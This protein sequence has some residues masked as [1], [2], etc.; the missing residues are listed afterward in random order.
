MMTLI[1][2]SVLLAAIL[3]LSTVCHAHPIRVA[4]GDDHPA[5][6]R[7]CPCV[8]QNGHCRCAKWGAEVWW[9]GSIKPSLYVHATEEDAQTWISEAQIRWPTTFESG[10]VYC[11]SCPCLNRPRFQRNPVAQSYAASPEFEQWRSRLQ[12]EILP[13][14]ERSGGQAE[15]LMAQLMKEAGTGGD[16]GFLRGLATALFDSYQSLN[17]LK[18]TLDLYSVLPSFD[19]PQAV[20]TAQLP[21]SYDI[22][23]GEYRTWPGGPGRTGWG[24]ELGA[25]KDPRTIV[26]PN[27]FKRV[28]DNT[29]V[30]NFNAVSL[31]QGALANL[32]FAHSQTL[33][34]SA[35]ADFESENG[36]YLQAQAEYES[37]AAEYERKAAAYEGKTGKRLPRSEPAAAPE[38]RRP[39]PLAL[40]PSYRP[41]EASYRDD[42]IDSPDYYEYTPPGW[43]FPIYLTNWGTSHYPGD[44]GWREGDKTFVWYP[45][46]SSEVFDKIWGKSRQSDGTIRDLEGFLTGSIAQTR[47]EEGCISCARLDDVVI[48]GRHWYVLL[49][50][51][52]LTDNS[53]HSSIYNLHYFTIDGRVI[54]NVSFNFYPDANTD[55][56]LIQAEAELTLDTSGD[57]VEE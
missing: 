6:A 51:A 50:E 12:S 4:S 16:P 19:L 37:E 8:A 40:A 52:A 38:P 26:S 23:T 32:L 36:D 1:R 14:L 10:I 9:R 54:R 15:V 31:S 43:G 3:A 41:T 33:H 24:D 17:S 18:A 28:L 22:E 44:A 42:A 55:F 2:G 34:E 21:S 7:L 39:A 30:A 25:L 53:N 47:T 5:S 48:S 49:T 13:K 27:K 45:T 35:V 29:L 56:A 20:F 57:E 46:E 11:L